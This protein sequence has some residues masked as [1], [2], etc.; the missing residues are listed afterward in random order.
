MPGTRGPAAKASDCVDYDK[1]NIG[2]VRDTSPPRAAIVKR[3]MA[4][5]VSSRSAQRNLRSRVDAHRPEGFQTQLKPGSTLVSQLHWSAGVRRLSKHDCSGCLRLERS[6]GGC[7]HPLESAALSRRVHS[8]KSH[9][10]SMREES[11]VGV[12]SGWGWASRRH[13]SP[14]TRL[15]RGASC[16]KAQR[17]RPTRLYRRL[18]V[19]GGAARRAGR[20]APKAMMAAAGGLSRSCASIALAG[21]DRSRI[22]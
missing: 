11:R 4:L 10:I 16:A 17:H 5:N 21:Q 22:T 8:A 18:Y 19:S 3:Y 13:P 7:L 12:V 9:A 15:G 1:C 6:P 2:Q 20:R 14:Q